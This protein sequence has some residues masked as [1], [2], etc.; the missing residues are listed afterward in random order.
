MTI[1]LYKQSN[2]WSSK[3]SLPD[4]W[5]FPYEST[6]D[7]MKKW[8]ALADDSKDARLLLAGLPA[9]RGLFLPMG[10]Q[11]KLIRKER[12]KLESA[13]LHNMTA[14]EAEAWHKKEGIIFF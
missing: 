2:A 13:G 3:Q 4:A 6:A 7:S 1:Q 10:Q 5:D 12:I 14:E 9:S 11:H 8:F